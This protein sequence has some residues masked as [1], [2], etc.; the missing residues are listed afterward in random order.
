M[1][2]IYCHVLNWKHTSTILL[3]EYVIISC[4]HILSKG[5]YMYIETS[6]GKFGDVARLVS[7]TF[8]VSVTLFC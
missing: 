3:L 2:Q 8:T 7:P 4:T 6:T 5:S 1:L